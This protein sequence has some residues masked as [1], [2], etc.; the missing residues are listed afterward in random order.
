[1][2]VDDRLETVLR[3][4]AAGPAAIRTQFRQLADLL[5]R[6]QSDAWTD[7][8][9]AALDRLDSLHDALGDEASADLLRTCALQS[10]AL[11]AHFANRGAKPALAA[12]GRARLTERQW[13]ALI[14]DLPVQSRGFL[15][16][17][18]DLG[19]LVERLLA[20]LGI[21][22]FALPEPEARMVQPAEAVAAAGFS[23][24]VPVSEQH[25]QPTTLLSLNQASAAS[26]NVLPQREGIGAI[27]R[28]IEAY[29]LSRAAASNSDNNHHGDTAAITNPD[30]ALGAEGLR[31]TCGSETTRKTPLAQAV[32]LRT[33]SAGTIIAADAAH[34]GM[35]IGHRPFTGQA[36]A[37]ATC[38]PNTLRAVRAHQP[39]NAGVIAFEGAEAISGAWRIDAAPAFDASSGQFQGYHA[40]LRRPAS[41]V[42]GLAAMAARAAQDDGSA[43]QMRQLLHELRTPINAIQGF[44]ELI[45]Q[46]LFGPTPH[47]YRSMAASIASDA[48]RMLAGFDDVE[49]LTKFESQ[50][51]TIQP[52]FEVKIDAAADGSD[53]TAL[54]SKLVGQLAPVIANREVKLACHWPETSVWVSFPLSALERGLWRLFSVIAEAAAYGEQLV[55]TL[56]QNARSARLVLPLP[57]ALAHR[58]GDALFAPESMTS[59]GAGGGAM[60]GSGFALRLAAAEIRSGGGAFARSE[61]QLMIDL[62]LLTAPPRTLSEHKGLMG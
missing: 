44:A 13:L 39:V 25:P 61:A 27:V 30:T 47:E 16:H 22:D 43:D 21:G 9:D 15:R 59:A 14:P 41:A 42:Q 46:Q 36:N 33:D 34:A 28:R 23:Q 4:V 58:E 32:D 8:H 40:R 10:P 35:L 6:A 24:S 48:A 57:A 45:Q 50:P 56:E 37:P 1:M 26:R 19:P 20:Q 12:I 62:P 11:V 55:L 49:R 53:L 3:T 51:S 17:R 18:R 31:Q 38:D 5:G 54:L 60:L 29:R 7:A 2:I 52:K